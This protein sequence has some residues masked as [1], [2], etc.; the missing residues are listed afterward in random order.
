MATIKGTL[1]G[2]REIV[3]REVKSQDELNALSEAESAGGPASQGAVASWAMI[4]RAI[5]E[6]DG[7]P[8]DASQF[9]PASLRDHFTAGQMRCVRELFDR[10]NGI[11]EDELAAFRSSVSIGA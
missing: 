9:T 4:L 7:K 5:V 11:A 2:G 10:L 8:F 6:L 1:P 3:L